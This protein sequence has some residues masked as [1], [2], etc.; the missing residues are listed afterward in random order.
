M[1]LQGLLLQQFK[2][3]T[4]QTINPEISTLTGG[5][6]KVLGNNPNRLAW[7]IINLGSDTAYLGFTLDVSAN[8]GIAVSPNGG[9]ASMI[10]DEDFETV[11]YELFC[12]GTASDVLYV[13]EVVT[14]E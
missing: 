1:T 4:R 10:W 3:K 5:V 7:V 9:F 6:D 11:G 14:A 2:V 12:K 8:K 13:V